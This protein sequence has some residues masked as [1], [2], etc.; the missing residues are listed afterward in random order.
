MVKKKKKTKLKRKERK[1]EEATPRGYSYHTVRKSDQRKKPSRPLVKRLLFAVSAALLRWIA[2]LEESEAGTPR[3]KPPTMRASRN[4]ARFP[5]GLLIDTCSHLL[6][7]VSEF[8]RTTGRRRCRRV[9]CDDTA[10]R[11]DRSSPPRL[12]TNKTH[13][14]A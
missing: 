10:V 4:R 7:I 6:P 9:A 5:Y 13:G 11:S 14:I 2:H 12:S 8:I 1:Q 3:K